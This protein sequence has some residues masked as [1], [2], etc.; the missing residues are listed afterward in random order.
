VEPRTRRGHDFLLA[1]SE[2]TEHEYLFEFCEDENGSVVEI[3]ALQIPHEKFE[4]F[5]R[6]ARLAGVTAR[7]EDPEETQK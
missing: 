5:K 2:A 3:S 7:E 1:Y 4:G 6:Q